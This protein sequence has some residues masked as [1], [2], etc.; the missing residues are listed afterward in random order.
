MRDKN[1][2]KE[3]EEIK[4]VDKRRVAGSPDSA[5]EPAPE[6]DGSSHGSGAVQE[7]PRGVGK[8]CAEFPDTMD[9]VTFVLSMSQAALLAMGC[10]PHPETG[11]TDCDLRSAKCTIDIL[12]VLQEKTK[13]NL[14]GEEERILERILTELRLMWVEKKRQT[15]GKQ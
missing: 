2:K 5:Q 6:D 13:G 8:T 1:N 11:K 12:E 3:K 7:P 10:G 15:G 14:T 4:V 9:F